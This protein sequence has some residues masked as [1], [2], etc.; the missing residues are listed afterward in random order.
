VRIVYLAP[1]SG[2]SGG[3][4]VIFQ[5]AE[6]LG[7]RGLAVTIASPSPPPFWF[8]L[9]A[10]RWE[11]AE[12][13]RSQALSR[14]DIRVATFW[15]TVASATQ[16]THGPV[17]HLCQGY[18]A[19]FSFYA[20]Q[21]EE[22]RAAYARPTRKLAVAPH[23]EDRLREEGYSPVTLIGQTFDQEEFPAA[24]DRRFDAECPTILLVGTFEADVKGIRETLEALRTARA[25]GLKFRL[26]RVSATPPGNEERAFG[27][28]DQQDVG[29][30]PSAMSAA[31]RSADL[32]IGP[33]HAEE[34]FGLPVLE[35]VS[36]GLPLLLSDTPGHRYIAR[37]AA[38]YFSCGN[39]QA[40]LSGLG[41]ILRDPTRR[42]R[43]SE[44]GP[45]E[46]SRF[47]TTEVVD[48]LLSEFERSTRFS[49]EVRSRP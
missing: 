9:K 8:P 44:L 40:L 17:F 21:R 2:I 16:E 20:H 30:L 42:R 25:E 48:R 18:E 12:F 32:L 27:L 41:S 49:Q 37:D 31:Y 23:I 7:R 22:I 10:A 28:A 11:Q 45:R 35:A 14:A 19:D 3:Q 47:R 6:E 5:Q 43:L 46:A 34:G 15:T 39:T 4:R 26:R 1:E 13:T 33:S 29:L 24:T 36:S 38:S